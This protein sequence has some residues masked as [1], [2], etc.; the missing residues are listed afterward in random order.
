MSWGCRMPL[1]N[2]VLFRYGVVDRYAFNRP[3]HIE[4]LYHRPQAGANFRTETGCKKTSE[5]SVL[6]KKRRNSA[7]NVD[8][9][10]TENLT[11]SPN[12]V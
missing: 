8:I 9:T 12:L 4:L 11:I 7:V 5:S 6:A 10:K 2:N 1:G 3:L